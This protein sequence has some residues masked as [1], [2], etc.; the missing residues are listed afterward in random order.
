M[1]SYRA[2]RSAPAPPNT[3]TTAMWLELMN[4][5]P[6]LAQLARALLSMTAGTASVE[7][8]IKMFAYVLTPER[9]AMKRETLRDHLWVRVCA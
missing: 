8:T 7:R 1:A 5:H 4:T 2:Y 9:N 6:L 3:S